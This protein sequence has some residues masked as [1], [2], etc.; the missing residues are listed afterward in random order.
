MQ[1]SHLKRHELLFSRT[2]KLNYHASAGLNHEKS[3][4]RRVR[5]VS[6]AISPFL[7]DETP[8]HEQTL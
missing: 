8:L 3:S 2:A 1:K 6:S 4:K 7:G 5:G